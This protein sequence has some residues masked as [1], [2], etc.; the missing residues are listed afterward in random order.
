MKETCIEL[1]PLLTQLAE[2]PDATGLE[3]RVA[4]HLARC[5]SCK[6][7]LSLQR[8]V[9]GLLRARAGA[10]QA[11]APGTLRARLADDVAA[12]GRS[13]HWA[14]M[15]IA[16]TAL[17]VLFGTGMY[18]LT[19]ASSSVLAAQLTLDHLKCVRLASYDAVRAPGTAVDDQDPHDATVPRIPP[20]PAHRASL[21]GKRRCL[22]GH[23]P[24]AHLIYDVGGQP[25]S[26]FV[27][28]RREVTPG[29]APIHHEV[30]GQRADV[31]SSGDRSYA[32]VGDVP[33]TVL[34]AIVEDFRSSAN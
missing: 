32:V 11:Q 33:A 1:A 5:P 34:S 8:D 24:V 9:H 7:M 30:F 12:S 2:Q 22:Y 28:P 13:W 14:R 17:L 15:P 10:L 20:L 18:G 16:A 31:W 21:I 3:P 19:S 6:R 29:A 26:V 27:M 25:V 23:G 4:D